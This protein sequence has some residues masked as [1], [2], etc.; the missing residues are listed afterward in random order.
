MP[1]PIDEI[2]K[3]I[4]GEL[5]KKSGTAYERLAAAAWK[6]FDRDADVAHDTRIRGEISKSLYQIDMEAEDDDG[7][8]AGEAKDYTERRANAKVGRPDLQKL[9]GALPELAVDTGKFFSATG[10]T[11]PARQ[12]AAAAEKIV[13][14]RIDLYELRGV[15]EKDL[16]GRIKQVI[17]RLHFIV[18]AYER[19][20]F[21][22]VWTPAGCRLIH[23]LVDAGKL[24]NEFEI[25]IEDIVDNNGNILD[26][27]HGLTSHGFG[28]ATSDKRVSGSWPIFGG[29][30]IVGGHPIPIYGITYEVEFNEDV[31]ELVIKASGRATLLLKSQDGSVD[32]ILQDIDLKRVTFDDAGNATIKE[33]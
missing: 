12:Y 14:K 32:K 26:S 31:R 5:P 1:S 10:Y 33:S 6:L 9:G 25:Y 30:L 29:H 8:H 18:P 11:K 22:P 27:I 21:N 23:E 19:S 24:T 28:G 3:S 16:E 17:C 15:I 2:Y 13:G 20:S 4:Y 7:R